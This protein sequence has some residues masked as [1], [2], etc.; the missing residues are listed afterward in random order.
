M[1]MHVAPMLPAGLGDDRRALL[2]YLQSL[3]PVSNE[4]DLHRALACATRD[5]GQPTTK[6]P[7]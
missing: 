7:T 1:T 5:R 6:A 3:K 4:T 2:A